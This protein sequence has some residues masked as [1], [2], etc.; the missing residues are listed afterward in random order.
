MVDIIYFSFG[1]HQVDQVL[2]NG[3]DVFLGEHLLLNVYVKTQLLVHSV[4]PNLSQVVTLLREEKLVDDALCCLIIRRFCI[5]QLP[6]NVFYRFLFG[7]G[8]ILLKG[9]VYDDLRVG[10]GQVCGTLENK[11]RDKIYIFTDILFFD[12]SG[13]LDKATLHARVQPKSSSA[14]C[15]Y[16]AR[17]NPDV[18]DALFVEWDV[19]MLEKND[20]QIY[21]RSSKY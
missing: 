13:L 11:T 15:D 2:H 7:I 5:T 20:E 21:M 4:T 12:R 14:F 8:R 17:S 3:D 18:E 9:V 6:V 19:Y 1:I 10:G 16:L